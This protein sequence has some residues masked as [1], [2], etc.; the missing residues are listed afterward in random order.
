MKYW[1]YKHQDGGIH[2]KVY[3][4]GL[5]HG[6]ASVDDAYDSPF[7]DDILEPFDANSREEAERLAKQRLSG[8]RADRGNGGG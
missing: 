7:V 2:L 4:E 6:R 3:R 1:A 8:Y 5:L